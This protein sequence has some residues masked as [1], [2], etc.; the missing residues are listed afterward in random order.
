MSTEP[1]KQ[2]RVAALCIAL[3]LAVSLLALAVPRLLRAGAALP[4]G[5]SLHRARGG[6]LLES[7]AL[8]GAITTL[9]GSLR[10]GASP[11][12]LSDLALLKLLRAPA[13]D[14][15][16]DLM[17]AMEAQE[18]SLSRAPASSDGWAR[19]SYAR[20]ALAGL[21]DATRDALELSFLTG[22]LERAPM[23]FRLQLVLK[24]WDAVG[25]ERRFASSLAIPLPSMPWSRSTCALRRWRGASSSRPWSG[26]RRT[27]LASSAGCGG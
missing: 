3:L 5:P 8:A 14:G 9:E 15:H 6:M 13:G 16:A 12:L 27:G 24:E 4:A 10:W 20:Y 21:N 26:L 11:V 23:V 17:E 22:R 25:P 19:L 1:G 7:E 18:A 2:E